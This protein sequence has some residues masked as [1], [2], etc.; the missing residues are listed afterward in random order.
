MSNVSPDYF[1]IYRIVFIVTLFLISV[2][3]FFVIMGLKK[4]QDENQRLREIQEEQLSL[5]KE[6]KG[7]LVEIRDVVAGKIEKKESQ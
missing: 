1:E 3:S 7:V 2:I 4:A 5:L 6:C